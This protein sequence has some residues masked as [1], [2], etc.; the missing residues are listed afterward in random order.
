[1]LYSLVGVDS[2]IREKALLEIGTLGNP[3]A[4][5]YAEH[6]SALPALIE[7]SSLFG[8]PIV[9]HLIQTLEK[10]EARDVVYDLL[11]KM[12]ASDNVFFIDEPF[13]DI[14]RVKRLEKFSKKIFDARV[15]KEKEISPFGLCTA[16]ARR[17][18]KEAWLEWMNVRDALEPEAIQGALWWKFQMVW[19]DTKEGRLS[20][21]TLAECEELGGRIMRSSV[22][23]HRGELDLGK[24]LES[25]ILSI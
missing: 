24:E 15:A 14:N 18:R 7:A 8:D 11:P 21:F 4:H 16:F 12:E 19:S 10:A 5:I 23:A 20:K 6:I 3:T 25:I 2:K 9:A 13:A 17:D 1:M 22:L